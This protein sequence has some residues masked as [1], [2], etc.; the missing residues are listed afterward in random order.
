VAPAGWSPA[1]EEQAGVIQPARTR[2]VEGPFRVGGASGRGHPTDQRRGPTNAAIGGDREDLLDPVGRA[3]IR[4]ARPVATEQAFGRGRSPRWS[5]WAALDTGDRTRPSGEA[6]PPPPPRRG[7]PTVAAEV[8]YAGLGGPGR[9]PRSG[10]SRRDRVELM[11][12]QARRSPPSGGAARH[13]PR[14]DYPV[15]AVRR[16]AR[17]ARVIARPRGERPDSTL[18]ASPPDPKAG[19]RPGPEQRISRAG[20]PPPFRRTSV[21]P[22]PRRGDDGGTIQ[23]V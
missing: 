23:P 21:P 17:T 22:V 14:R 2:L 13:T 12:A 5:G 11:R 3:L 6:R 15:G 9:G 1:V 10:R 8:M 19:S 7:S 4:A 18:E 20:A 16:A